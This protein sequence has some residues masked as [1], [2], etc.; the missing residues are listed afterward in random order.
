[1]SARP[2]IEQLKKL[3]YY[4]RKLAEL[5]K[6]YATAPPKRQDTIKRLMAPCLIIAWEKVAGKPYQKPML[7]A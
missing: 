4:E 7:P 6:E 5:R 2:T 1:M 3:Q